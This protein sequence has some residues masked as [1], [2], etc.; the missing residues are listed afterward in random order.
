[1]TLY[2]SYRS[3][4]VGGSVKDRPYILDGDGTA[5][6]LQLNRIDVA[7]LTQRVTGKDLLF[8]AHGFNVNYRDGA[9]SLGRLDLALN[10]GPSELFIGILW[11]GD[12]WI[13]AIN[14]PFEGATSIKCGQNLAAFCND[15]LNTAR[16]LS[17]ASHSL[18]GRLV[19]EAV[20]NLNRPARVTCLTAGAVN[21]DCFRTE[22]TA[23][24]T[25]SVSISTLASR[26]DKVLQLAFPLGD[27]FAD[28]LNQDHAPGEP[29]LGRS[30]P[31]QP[32]DANVA[33]SQIPNGLHFD[34]GDYFPPSQ[35][36]AIGP[37][38]RWP[39]V[40]AFILRAFR[41][42]RQTWPPVA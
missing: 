27:I 9:R 42:E 39:N 2:L 1:M 12:W 24:V 10:L 38:D 34:H 15:N 13:P 22:Y 32:V 19:L 7:E 6:P 20:E 28:L 29:A 21:A 14:Y 18:G 41:G 30:G 8:G 25:S 31:E 11:P 33:P 36:G 17:F 26:E 37:N 16:S 23:S 3:A 5:D 40:V 4:T 35:P